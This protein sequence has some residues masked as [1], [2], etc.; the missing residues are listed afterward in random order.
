MKPIKIKPTNITGINI[1]LPVEVEIG[2]ENYWGYVEGVFHAD[3]SAKLE[4]KKKEEED[5]KSNN[6]RTK[7]LQGDSRV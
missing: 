4:P 6:K 1:I 5:E 2:R 7:G 3:Q